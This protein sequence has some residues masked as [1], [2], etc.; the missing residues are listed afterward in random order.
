MTSPMICVAVPGAADQDFSYTHDPKLEVVAGMRVL[1]PFGSRVLLGITRPV[2]PTVPRGVELRPVLEWLDPVHRPTLP[3]DVVA[4]CEWIVRYYLAPAGEVYRLALPGLL[5]QTD[6]RRAFV[7]TKGAELAPRIDQ[8]PLLG[9]WDSEQLSLGQRRLLAAIANVGDVG[10]PLSALPGLRPRVVAATRVIGELEAQGLCRIDFEASTLAARTETH[11]RRT[12][13]L[14]GASANE[15]KLRDVIGRSKQRRALLDYLEGQP[16]DWV[17]LSELRGPFPRVRPLLEPL[18]AADLVN[19]RE[20][21]R[22]DDPF[23]TDAPQPSV[24]SEPT[25]EQAAAL[26][27]LCAR[28]DAGEF[29]GALLHGVT[30]SGKTEVYLQLIAHAREE[31][32]G[33]IVLVPEISLTPQLADRFRARFGETVAVLHSGLSPRQRYDAWEHIRRGRRRIVIGARSAVFAPVENLRV[34]VV[35]EEHDSSFKQE[36]GVRYHARDVALV[37][38]RSALAVAVLGSATPS[39]ETYQRARHE[40]IEWLRLTKRPTPRPLPLVEVVP[41]AVHRPDPATML[42]ARLREAIHET[43]TA[44][45]QVIIFLNRRGYTTGLLCRACGAMQAC[46]DCSAPSMTYHLARNRLLCHLCGHVEG[47]PGACTACGGDDLSH[48]GAGTERVELGLL[49]AFAQFRVLRLD[50]DTSRGRRLLETLRRF[51]DREA[52]ILVGTQMLAKGHDFPGVTLVGIVSADQGLSMPDPRAAERCFQ[53]LTQVAGRAG[54]GERLGRVILQTYAA[55]H[56][57]IISAAQ[58]DYEGFAAKELDQRRELG[59]P[60]FGHLA[61]LRFVGS[62]AVA[63]ERVASECAR[64]VRSRL[65][66]RGVEHAGVGVLGP[67]PSPIERINRRT[68]WQLL[69]R[70]ADRRPLHGLLRWLKAQRLDSAGVRVGIDVDPQTLL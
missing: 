47:M 40:R 31:G 27:V 37:R 13:Y 23:A 49:E 53:L 7:T 56:P 51:R 55:D 48:S 30:G 1:V 62:D 16:D 10:L 43:V 19:A 52:D 69:L 11:V 68:R 39:L 8:G 57:A 3:A 44:G 58:H 35:D 12:D 18:L 22:A 9:G 28:L 25:D 4:L 20:L 17:G 21:P 5:T 61:L 59:N 2:E 50:R 70:A 38:A 6:A 64:A 32:G 46:P 65:T 33:A 24:P 29:T 42:T 34:I 14:R 54:R 60:P 36:E 15:E 41:L 45:E 66:A 67:V 26:A 63:V